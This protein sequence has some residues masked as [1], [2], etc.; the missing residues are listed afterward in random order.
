ML[1]TGWPCL[2]LGGRYSWKQVLIYTWRRK[3]EDGREELINQTEGQRCVQT[4]PHPCV[5]GGQPTVR[6][7]HSQ[8][9]SAAKYTGRLASWHN[10]NPS[11]STSPHLGCA[12]LCSAQASVDLD[13]QNIMLDHPQLQ[14]HLVS[15]L[16]LLRPGEQFDL[17]SP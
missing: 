8:L 3:R 4:Q 10:N 11:I 5:E 13:Q 16:F 12:L 15:D 6:P 14:Q 9:S 1:D 7:Q 2:C 17:V